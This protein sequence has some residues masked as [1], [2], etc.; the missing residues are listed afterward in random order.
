LAYSVDLRERVLEVRKEEGLTIKQ[1]AERFLV[2]ERSI[3]RWLNL[4]DLEAK[5]PGPKESRT[6][7]PERLQEMVKSKPDAYLDEYAEMLNSKPSTVSYNLKKLGFCRKKNHPLQR[8]KRR[9]A[10]NISTGN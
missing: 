6:I 8:E 3:N 2:S 7:C 10:E 5:K 4:E 1:A 9:K